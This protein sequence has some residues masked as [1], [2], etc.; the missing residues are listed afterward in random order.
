M[1]KLSY[2]IFFVGVLSFAVLACDNKRFGSFSM[3]NPSMLANKSIQNQALFDDN[4]PENDAPRLYNENIIISKDLSYVVDDTGKMAPV[5]PGLFV[6]RKNDLK[7][8]RSFDKGSNFFEV[9]GRSLYISGGNIVA[10]NLESGAQEWTIPQPSRVDPFWQPYVFGKYLI[11][12]LGSERLTY[13]YDRTSGELRWKKEFYVSTRPYYDPMQNRLYVTDPNIGLIAVAIDTGS[14][15][16]QAQSTVRNAF[17]P[18]QS[19]SVVVCSAGDNGHI[20]AYDK[21]NGDLVWKESGIQRKRYLPRPVKYK[22]YIIYAG[23]NKISALQRKAGKILWE[24][25]Y[26]KDELKIIQLHQLTNR[27]NVT[28]KNRN[29]IEQ[30]AIDTGE[31]IKK[32]TVNDK[33]TSPYAYDGKTIYYFSNNTLFAEKLDLTEN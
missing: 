27:L 1:K 21:D 24:R 19:G 22:D 11:V 15:L 12:S 9:S 23:L 4:F 26:Q 25:S 2:F 28:F 32:V 6:L 16:W 5:P 29:Y 14:V 13:C 31:F 7:L 33:I 10:I 20:H 8:S 30:L 3:P 17:Q 18:I